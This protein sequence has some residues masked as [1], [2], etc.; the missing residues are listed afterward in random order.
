MA[1]FIMDEK[2]KSPMNTIIGL[3]ERLHAS[4]IDID[5][6]AYRL[7]KDEGNLLAVELEKYQYDDLQNARF[8]AAI[9][10]GCGYTLIHG[11]KLFGIKLNV[12]L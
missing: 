8:A 11:S 7:S 10:A 5:R 2:V 1:N 12:D 3:V 4:D 6:F 9:R